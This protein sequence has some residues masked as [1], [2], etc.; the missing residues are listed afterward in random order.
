[1]RNFDKFGVMIDCS[2]D[3]VPNVAGLKRFLAAIA[4]MGYNVAMLYTEDTYEVE[5]EPYFGYKRGRYSMA[6]LREIDDFAASVGIELVPFIQTLAHVGS[7][8]RWREYRHKIFDIDDIM[9]VDEPRTYELIENIFSTLE[10]TFRSRLVHIGMDEAHNI[11]LGKYKDIHGYEER[12]SLLMRHLGKVCEIAR[13]HGFES[14]MMANDL[15]FSLA[16]GVFCTDEIRDFPPEITEKVPH[17]C[18][19]VYWDYFATD[20]ARYDAMMI[21]SKKLSPEVWFSGGAWTWGTFAPHNRYSIKRN[22]LALSRCIKNGVHKAFFTLW[23]DN[24]GECAYGAVLPALMHAAAVAQDMPEAEMK[25]RFHEIT[26]ENFDDFMDLDLP[27][28]IFGENVPVESPYFQ[29]SACNYAKTHLYDDPFLGTMSANLQ[30]DD[31]SLLAEYAARLYAHAENSENYAHLYRTMA[32]LC[33]VMEKKLLLAKKTRA[34]YAAGDKAALRALAEGDYAEC[35]RRADVFYEAFRAQWYSINKTYG[36]EIHD[37]RLG[38]LSRRLASC[39]ERLLAYASG[40]TTKIA[41]L[42][43]P[44]LPMDDTYITSWA[45]MISA[46][47]T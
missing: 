32:C 46:N 40:E 18:E 9:L 10:K 17:G 31:A 39:R 24:G 38:G 42:E 35:I 12:Y 43:E 19:M 20:P 34:L 3:A 16:P 26:G 37:A 30:A 28:Y 44:I 5:N 25:A 47:W 36:F 23:G 21:S 8:K 13:A 11:G 7:L 2:R 4:K 14:T 15:F 6:E 29:H 41:E 22:A 1:M 45:E 27:N 33:D